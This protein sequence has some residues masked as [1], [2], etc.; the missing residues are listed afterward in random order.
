M[1]QW[2]WLAVALGAVTC[3]AAPLTAQQAEPAGVALVRDALAARHARVEALMFSA[4][5]V[6]HRG[7]HLVGEG[8]QRAPALERARSLVF[9][10][11]AGSRSE[12]IWSSSRVG[13]QWLDRFDYRWD[14]TD[15][16]QSA[17][18]CLGGASVQNNLI[19]SGTAR[20]AS[21]FYFQLGLATS[22]GKNLL[23]LLRAPLQV[24]HGRRLRGKV[25]DVVRSAGAE[26][27]VASEL[28]GAPLRWV[29]HEP[30]P[31]REF[32]V[33]DW[34]AYAWQGELALPRRMLS[35]RFTTTEAG[36]RLSSLTLWLVEAVS[37]DP[38]EVAALDPGG[39]QV[40]VFPGATVTSHR[41]LPGEEIPRLGLSPR[42]LFEEAEQDG[43]AW[44]L[45]LAALG[46][47]TELALPEEI[48]PAAGPRAEP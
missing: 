47:D 30:A 35:R 3:T 23:E 26:I 6:L 45:S 28:G 22:Q 9:L 39:L 18:L 37:V 11:R 19:V 4:G 25:C 8:A 40:P 44:G 17:S 12:R 7:F 36:L 15:S 48:P 32:V 42:R 34:W 16:A 20:G 14:G 33:T 5:Q 10:E 29:Q 27:W 1:R 46:A 13:G 31:G 21:P 38:D 43:A 41:T 2:I 24:E